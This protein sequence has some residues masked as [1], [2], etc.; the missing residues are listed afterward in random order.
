[1][2]LARNSIIYTI[3][4]LLPA[5]AGFL[6]L[7]IYS[8]YLS[9]KE[10][11]IIASMEVLMYI[12]GVFVSF[13]LERAAYRFYFDNEDL[14]W[15]RDLL[16]TLHYS[17]IGMALFWFIICWVLQDFI[18]LIFPDIPFWPIYILVIGRTCTEVLL[19]VPQQYLQVAERP[20][21]YVVVSVA[22]FTLSVA[23]A[24]LFLIVYE[25]GAQGV[26][27]GNL[28]S[29]VL[30]APVGMYIAFRLFN[31][32]FRFQMLKEALVFC[33]P[34]VPTL[35]VA[36]VIDLSDRIFL[37][38]Y[39]VEGDLGVYGMAYKIASGYLLLMGAYHTAYL[40]RFYKLASHPEQ[41]L[42]KSR[43]QIEAKNNVL[44]HLVVLLLGVMWSYELV[45]WFLS[46]EYAEVTPI[47]R[48]IL[49]SHLFACIPAVTSSAALMQVKKTRLNMYAAMAAA[50]I[51]LILNYILIPQYGMYGAATATLLS[52]VILFF[53]QYL[54]SRSVYF[55][56]I[57]LG[58]LSIIVLSIVLV[59]FVCI[60]LEQS[61]MVG[62][63]F[64]GSVSFFIFLLIWKFCSQNR[65]RI[66]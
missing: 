58:L 10:Y 61:F 8:Q 40:P 3:G 50:A 30:L 48:L 5:A 47:L 25:Q 6:L 13:N 33:W 53:I 38:H 7:P 49:F 19:R 66:S 54:A 28:L 45:A 9:P 51:N 29:S 52:M 44:L 59:T 55:I 37:A 27:T 60:E 4:N 65:L 41:S 43:L 34:F 16:F 46:D 56:N 14:Q 24:M 62:I 22:R 64:K 36:W 1:M 39:A 20:V 23:F 57:P 21:A 26:L 15:R 17:A 18:S 2:S 32:R 63:A 12:F 31:G 35:L 11:S 42:V